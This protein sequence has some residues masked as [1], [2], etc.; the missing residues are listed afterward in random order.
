MS[1]P[2]AGWGCAWIILRQQ[3]R[4]QAFILPRWEMRNQFYCIHRV[5]YECKFASLGYRQTQREPNKFASVA[6]WNVSIKMAHAKNVEE[7]H[8][9][10]RCSLRCRN[11][12]I[13]LSPGPRFEKDTTRSGRLRDSGQRL[14]S[15][16]SSLLLKKCSS[17]AKS[18]RVLEH[19]IKVSET[20]FVSRHVNSF[21]S[22]EEA[23]QICETCS[24]RVCKANIWL[25]ANVVSRLA[26][27]F[28]T[29]RKKICQMRIATP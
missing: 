21:A 18:F 24:L 2:I 16:L 29:R 13:L 14:S 28:C 11:D 15:D 1:Q 17:R 5:T 10:D 22:R 8:R 25:P 9:G 3:R 26:R 27:P 12:A 7:R 4:R 23:Q 20:R 6:R 19:W